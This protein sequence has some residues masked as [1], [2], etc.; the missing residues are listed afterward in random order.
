MD[1]WQTLVG[2]ALLGTERQSPEIPAAP[3]PPTEGTRLAASLQNL[4]WDNP[5]QALLGSA[6][7]V[8]LHS[9]VGQRPPT[10]SWDPLKSCP[11][12]DRPRCSALISRY[13][14]R[15]WDEDA[16]LLPELL[17]LIAQQNQRVPEALLPDLLDMGARQTALRPSII[18]VLGTRGQWLA[19]QNQ[20]WEYGTGITLSTTDFQS[21]ALQHLWKKGRRGE[22]TSLLC[23]WRAE[24]ANGAREALEQVWASE[25]AKDREAFLSTLTPH[26]SMM[27]EP[28]LEQALDDRAKGVRKAAIALLRQLPDSRLCQRM[29]QRITPYLQIHHSPQ[30][31]LIIE[32]VLPEDYDSTWDR[33]GIVQLRPTPSASKKQSQ[34]QAKKQ[35]K[36]AEWLCQ[37]LASTPLR[38]WLSFGEEGKIDADLNPLD[39]IM[40]AAD[41]H[42]WQDVLLKGWAI[43]TQRQHNATW[44]NALLHHLEIKQ[45]HTLDPQLYPALRTLLTL[46]QQEELLSQ[47]RPA[48]TDEDC[49]LWLQQV[50]HRGS[51]PC[52]PSWSLTFSHLVWQTIS[53][54]LHANTRQ[55]KQTRY[56]YFYEWLGVIK[57]LGLTLH[58][59]IAPDVAKGLE[60][61]AQLSSFNQWE[62]ALTDFYSRLNFRYAIHQAF[63]QQ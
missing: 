59:A 58:P 47:Q 31:P 11:E 42:P 40:Q 38:T 23:Q 60:T 5:A 20:M 44:A 53:Q 37:L 7:A 24:D 12:G 54:F 10:K 8:A 1:W 6:G 52:H 30:N 63:S 15:C 45:W 14:K 56:A 41:G 19:T 21:D 16:D 57:D 22:R 48:P 29:V 13:V 3:D 26:L 28:F 49:L 46:E 27:D 34:Q 9:Q 32:V 35:G 39:R 18:A 62:R 25:L 50:A 36:R 2:T 33:D 17:T 51:S 4:A 43:A 55:S 61:L